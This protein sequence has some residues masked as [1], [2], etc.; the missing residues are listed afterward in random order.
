MSYSS[1]GL[2]YEL[3]QH[4][5]RALEVLEGAGYDAWVVGGWV[6]D[7][8]I[9]APCH[10]VDITTSARWEQTKEA[11]EAAGITVHETGT[12]HGTVTVVIDNQPIEI[13]TYR[14]DG[15][16]SDHRHPDEVRFVKSVEEDLARR[17]FTINAMAYHPVRG[18][19]DPFGGRKDLKDGLIRAVGD[20]RL[21]FSEDAL[22]VLRAVRFAARMGFEIEPETHEAL[23]E[24]A[25][26]LS[27]VAQERIGQEV[28]AI[29]RT[30]KAGWVLMN[31]PEALCAAIPEIAAMVGFDQRTPWHAYDVLVHTAH[32]CCAC[33]EFT[34]GLA[35]AELRWAALLH[36]I[37]KPV[38]FT[39]D[40]AGRGHFYG[41]PKVGAVMSE[42]IMHRLALPKD[43]IQRVRTLIR[44]HDHMMHPT[45]RSIR[46]T[47]VKLEQ[48][49]PGYARSL[50][51]QLID[52]KRADAVSKVD[53]AAPYAIEADK[54]T[55]A[56]HQELAKKP[57]LRAT[58]L[59][60]DGS[61]VMESLQ[62]APGPIVGQ[63]L[64]ELLYAVTNG[65]VENDRNQLLRQM[66]K[67]W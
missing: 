52:L 1:D 53:R 2:A 55:A 17:D 60:V 20:P 25:P 27:S 30:G 50:I 21:R 28:D 64:N 61:D 57:P 37:A 10:D 43:F 15:T 18:L 51:Y 35:T 3:P 63:I 23:V 19:F 48:A 16:Y 39:V 56:T 13:T 62:I 34:V 22:R 33:E 4:A 42:T 44:F 5:L 26:T 41:H 59:E 9:G 45:Q 8:L 46:R 49:C 14:V 66:R 58:D 31:E 11:F 65:E 67:D 7:A 47:L 6:R 29:V 32:V 24:A 38:T 12:A 54:L 40:K 36:D